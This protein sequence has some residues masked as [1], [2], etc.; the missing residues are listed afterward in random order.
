M[1]YLD[2]VDENGQPTGETVS[3][4]E[5]HQKGIRHRTAHVWIVRNFRGEKMQILLQKRSQEKDSFPGFYDT[6]S[7]G[8][9]PA[10]CEPV[11]SALREMEEELSISAEPEQLTYIGKFLNEYEMVFHGKPFRD[12]EVTFVYVYQGHVWIEDLALQASEIDEVQW[13]DLNEVREEIRHNRERFCMPEESMDILIAWLEEQKKI[14][15]EQEAREKEAAAKKEALHRQEA[16]RVWTDELRNMTEFAL[17]ELDET[18]PLTQLQK[19]QARILFRQF[20]CDRTSRV[21]LFAEGFRLE[22]EEKIAGPIYRQL[23]GE[24]FPEGCELPELVRFRDLCLQGVC[25]DGL[26]HICL[27]QLLGS[28]CRANAQGFASLADGLMTVMDKRIKTYE[29]RREQLRRSQEVRDNEPP[30]DMDEF[31][32]IDWVITH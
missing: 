8:H 23:M 25:R 18:C 14:K 24:V 27:K 30:P 21:I 15:A 6:S 19:V 20:V 9:I 1:E 26:F 13:F 10:G 4:E 32:Y 2:I 3:R 29:K 7:A 5:A 22:E 16:I 11:P 17:K 12:N 31:E 28:S